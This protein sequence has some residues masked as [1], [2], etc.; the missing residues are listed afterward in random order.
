MKSNKRAPD[1]V[2]RL[3]DISKMPA[4]NQIIFLPKTMF[5]LPNLTKFLEG[6]EKSHVDLAEHIVYLVLSVLYCSSRFGD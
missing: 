4:N 6:K 1:T 2:V 3:P 5:F